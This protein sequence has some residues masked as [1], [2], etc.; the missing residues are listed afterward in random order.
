MAT[1]LSRVKAK[2]LT[3]SI[4]VVE[5]GVM[6]DCGGTRLSP[7]CHPWTPGGRGREV[8]ETYC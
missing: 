1:V 2:V 7:G 3:L 5:L 6:A 8:G 4:T